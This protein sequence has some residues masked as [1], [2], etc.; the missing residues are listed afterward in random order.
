MSGCV[1][2]VMVAKVV[3]VVM[4]T[5]IIMMIMTAVV[6]VRRVLYKQGRCGRMR[7][8]H[9]K[10]QCNDFSAFAFEFVPRASDT[11]DAKRGMN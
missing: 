5:V 11:I 4:V 7:G 3:I 6:G 1:L 2:M 9:A 10:A 8:N